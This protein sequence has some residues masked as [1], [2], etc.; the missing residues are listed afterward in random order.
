MLSKLKRLPLYLKTDGFSPTVY[1]IV[2]GQIARFHLEKVASLAFA[3]VLSAETQ[4]LLRGGK[5]P[6]AFVARESR[7]EDVPALADFFGDGDGIARRLSDGNLCFVLLADGAIRAAEWILLGP[8]DYVEDWRRTRCVFRLPQESCWVY[9]GIGKG[10]G[11][12]GTLM[13]ALP[14][15]LQQRGVRVLYTQIDVTN[16]VSLKSHAAL[17]FVK[18]G[19]IFHVRLGSLFMTLYKAAGGSWRRLPGRLHELGLVGQQA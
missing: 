6:R 13:K 17:G 10:P 5:V 15:H 8:G 9:D 1:R 2:R 3:H 12:W 7:A 14:V 4:S 16:S 18:I 11:A 19:R